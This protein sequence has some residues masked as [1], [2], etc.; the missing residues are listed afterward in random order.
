MKAATTP[1]WTNAIPAI[2]LLVV[3]GV[4]LPAHAQGTTLHIFV[5]PDPNEDVSLAATTLDGNLPAAIETPSGIATAPDPQKPP[6]ADKMYTGGTVDDTPDSTYEPDRDTRQPNVENY[7]DPFSPSTAPFKRLR[8][9]DSVDAD[10]TL[11]VANKSTS[12]VSVGGEAT[13]D[14]E[15]FYGDFSVE[16]LPDEL[17]RIPSVGP[18][19]RVLKMHVSP[20]AT[21]SM[22]RDGADNW[23]MRGSE[24][25]RVRVVMEIAI[26]RATFGSDFRDVGF[27][28]LA[29]FV[30]EFA[31]HPAQAERVF[32]A[33][34][35]GR[36]QRP[37]ENLL[38]MVEYYR[39]FVPSDD[40]PRTQN[41]IFLDL[42]LTKK[43][44][45]RHRAFAFLVTALEL[46]LPARMVVNEAHA[47][48]EVFDSVLWHR[49]DLGGAAMDLDQDLDPSRPQHQPPND[50]FQWPENSQNS[51]GHG[52]ATREQN[53]NSGTS[54][55]NGT[56][57]NGSSAVD[58]NPTGP[59]NSDL[60]PS[61]LDVEVTEKTVRRG[62]TLRVKGKVVGAQPCKNVRVDIVM[63]TDDAA[64]RVIGSLSTDE[65][66]AYEGS[67]VVPRDM[68][69]GDY[70]V[71]VVTRGDKR[72]GSGRSE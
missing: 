12:I 47:W 7:E 48:V 49:I 20:S 2:S 11:K 66:G 5:P 50:P 40:P 63:K 71:T 59:S 57:P 22:L 44:V 54:D 30:P 14:D 18:G 46:G 69:A 21:V 29:R 60:P 13:G 38:K 34:G 24:R 31:H 55:P 19:S 51:S 53:D 1:S 33:I 39:A 43:G 72:C 28:D 35:I 10:Y 8:A 4:A 62:K 41:D 42:A 15:P 36:N 26:A 23:F 32:Q 58:N 37:R 27:E 25:K 67:V 61:K 16:L 3:L 6:D 45:C 9:Y 52:L 56:D 17:V 68:T 65:E 64:A 70:D